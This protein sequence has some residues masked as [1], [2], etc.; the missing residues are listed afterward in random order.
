MSSE[1]N[2]DPVAFYSHIVCDTDV[3]WT[4]TQLPSISGEHENVK[5]ALPCSIE[6]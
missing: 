5:P 1:S 3:S 6:Q 4:P 2:A